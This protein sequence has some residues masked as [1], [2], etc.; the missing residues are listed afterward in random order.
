MPLGNEP[1]YMG[2][3]IVGKTTSAAFGYRVGKPVAL[4]YIDN[5]IVKEGTKVDVDIAGEH[6]RGRI[7]MQCAYDPDGSRMKD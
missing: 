3:K 1:V 5:L 7:S 2:G 4:A 6:W